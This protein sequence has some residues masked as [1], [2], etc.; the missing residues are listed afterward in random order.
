MGEAGVDYTVSYVTPDDLPSI[1]PQVK[2]YLEGAV[3]YAPEYSLDDV[4]LSVIQEDS[5]MFVVSEGKDIQGV[6]VTVIE[7][8]PQRSYVQIHLLG[9]KNMKAWVQTLRD[10]LKQF[11]GKIGCDGLSIFARRGWA[12]IF[13]DLRYERIIMVDLLGDADVR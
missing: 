12:K 10:K 4:I 13:P 2:E 7:K 6:V 3:E 9:G 1:F 8:H 11:A 5:Q